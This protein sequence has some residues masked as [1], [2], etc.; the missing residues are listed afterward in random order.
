MRPWA[1]LAAL[2][3]LTIAGVAAQEKGQTPK[4]EGPPPEER[5]EE[6]RVKLYPDDDIFKYVEDDAPIAYRGQKVLDAKK[7]FA[8]A[9]ELKAYDYVLAFASKQKPELMAK[10]ATRDVPYPSLFKPIR[11]DYL[12]E[13][14]HFEG[15][16]ALL[17]KVKAT[18]GLRGLDNIDWLYEAWIYPK[19]HSEPLCLMVS[20]L[21]PGVEPGED[22]N[23]NVAF[24]AYLF[25]LFHYESRG[26]KAGEAGKNQWRR[27]PLFLGKTFENKGSANDV[28]PT[29]TDNM[30][31]TIVLGLCAIAG[32]VAVLGWWL[33]R[34]GRYVEEERRRR[35]EETPKFLDGND[36]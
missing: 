8:A 36:G 1:A 30:L 9:Q 18:E 23:I 17:I 32:T 5:P 31:L 4:P 2:C 15:R 3:F 20:E 26:A 16:L 25:K 24:D 10:Y 12:R 28:G 14:M 7:D 27:A 6:E 29:Y 34:G 13:L 35:L 19:G 33:K 22:K 21:P 11:Q